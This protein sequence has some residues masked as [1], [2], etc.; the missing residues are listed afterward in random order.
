MKSQAVDPLRCAVPLICNGD[1][2][3]T[4][5]FTS[6]RG[7]DFLSRRLLLPEFQGRRGHV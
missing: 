2:R 7:A 4:M 3:S 5:T 1:I 6:T